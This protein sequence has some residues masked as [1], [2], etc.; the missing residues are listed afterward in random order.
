MEGI[1]LQDRI[2]GNDG[3]E[4]MER[5]LKWE[6]VGK[7]KEIRTRGVVGSQDLLEIIVHMCVLLFLWISGM[8][9]Q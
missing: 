3:K 5:K 9:G 1:Y 4:K 7:M 6:P 2:L 8:K